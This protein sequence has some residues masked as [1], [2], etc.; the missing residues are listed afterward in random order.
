MRLISFLLAVVLASWACTRGASQPT[1]SQQP[2]VA[3]AELGQGRAVLITG[4]STGIGRSTTELLRERGFHVFAGARK[5]ADLEALDALENVTA[6]RLD[7]T[8]Q[9]DIDAAVKTVADSG[10]GL[11]GLINNAGVVVAGPLVEVTDE[12]LEF[13][14][15]VNVKGPHRV[16]KAFAPM[17]IESGGRIATTG[18]ISGVVCW[19]LGGPYTMSKHAIEAYTDVLAME[20]APLGVDV[21][22]I[23]P[24]NYR[25]EIMTSMAERMRAKGYTT[26][27]SLFE[28]QMDGLFGSRLD[29]G[30]YK[31]PIEVAQAFLDFLTSEAPKRRYMV[32]PHTGE[33]EL[34]VKAS[35][36]RAVQRNADQPYE[37][38]RDELVALLDELLAE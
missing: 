33:A 11:F 29:R 37:L 5:A 12:D 27:G 36:R 22:V 26:E 32:V 15:D 1:A 24:G 8:V 6:V 7:V 31:D 30:Q 4:A 9:A 14:L 10:R 16:T 35:L 34:T 38:S 17:L 18:S 25:S 13:Q 23:E 2:A 28:A 3:A 21:A 19:G 20:L